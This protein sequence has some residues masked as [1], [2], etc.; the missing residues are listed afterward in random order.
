M[1][2]EEV[3]AM[4]ERIYNGLDMIGEKAE[5]IGREKPDWSLDELGKMSDIE[6]DIAESFKHLIKIHVMLSEH[7][8]E[9]Y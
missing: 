1:T 2:N 5:K 9:K 6:K 3:T 4:K 7:S 8:V